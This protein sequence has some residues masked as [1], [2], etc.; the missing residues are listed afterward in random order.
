[1]TRLGLSLATG[2]WLIKGEGIVENVLDPSLGEILRCVSSDE[3]VSGSF[4]TIGC[5]YRSVATRHR[6]CSF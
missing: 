4:E 6:A 3:I 5:E 2:M 1:M